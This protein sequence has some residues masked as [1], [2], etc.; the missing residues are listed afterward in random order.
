MAKTICVC[1]NLGCGEQYGSKLKEKC[2][3]YCKNCRTAEG[4]A[5]IEQSRNELIKKTNN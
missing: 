5:A 3:I 4:R 1:T 2:D